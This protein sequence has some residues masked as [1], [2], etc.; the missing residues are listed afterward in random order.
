LE[1]TRGHP[2]GAVVVRGESGAIVVVID[3][4]S[5][6]GA[7]RFTA[8]DVATGAT[9]GVRVIDEPARCWPASTG[10]MWCGDGGGRTH[11]V[12]VPSF[13][14]ATASDADQASRSWLGKAEPGCTFADEIVLRGGHLT[15]GDGTP[16]PLVFHLEHPSGAEP[17]TE[18]LPGTP[19]FFSP[20]FVRTDDPDLLL[21]QHDTALDRPDDVQLSRVGIDRNVV[22]TAELG[23]RCETAAA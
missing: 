21:V 8:I 20:T 19:R 22:W 3:R 17:A 6:S 2:D 15:F 12:A 11:L 5:R 10:K 9:R 13:E 1:G 23:G 14:A 7:H 18:T 4:V 16:R